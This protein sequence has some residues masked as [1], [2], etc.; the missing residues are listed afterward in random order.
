MTLDRNNNDDINQRAS[1]KKKRFPEVVSKFLLSRS[2]K[3]GTEL[4]GLTGSR[5]TS[6]EFVDE[7]FRERLILL[8]TKGCRLPSMRRTRLDLFRSVNKKDS[9]R[10][11][12]FYT[13]YLDLTSHVSNLEL[14]SRIIL[15]VL[16]N[17][18]SPYLSCGLNSQFFGP[19]GDGSDGY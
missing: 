19:E 9:L 7:E 16:I 4:R 10:W 17:V 6:Y 14:N 13:L 11:S 18:D 1:R 15:S 3:F 8:S 12:G 2:L 5:S